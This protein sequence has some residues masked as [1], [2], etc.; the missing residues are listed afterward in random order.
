M[1]QSE[2]HGRWVQQLNKIGLISLNKL[3]T[4]ENVA[5]LL[6]KHVPR[7]VLDKPAGLMGY[8]FL[9]EETQKFQEYTNINQ[10][11]WNQRVAVEKLPVFDDGENESSENDVHSFVDKTTHLPIAVLR[12]GVEMSDNVGKTMLG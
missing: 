12:R 4:L 1:A 2:T 7:A 10:N 6:T 11:Y 3:N 5:D 9:G 8:T